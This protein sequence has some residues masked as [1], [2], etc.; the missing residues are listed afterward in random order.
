MDQ[1]DRII[2]EKALDTLEELRATGVDL[3]VISVNTSPSTLRDPHLADRLI[4]QIKARHLEASNLTIEV[5]ECTLV[6][7]DDIILHMIETLSAAGFS[8][9]LDNFGTRYPSM[10]NLSRLRLNAIKLDKSLIKPVPDARADSIISALVTL[11][12]NLDM[13][14]VAE[15]VETPGHLETVR[16]LKRDVLQGRP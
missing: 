2:I 16:R 4:Q 13:H 8:I 3:P 1:I 10:S 7:D 15:G 12:R 11:S 14:V 6:K 5:L 9:V